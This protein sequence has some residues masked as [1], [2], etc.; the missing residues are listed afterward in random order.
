MN[1]AENIRAKLLE[2]LESGALPLKACGKAFLQVLRPVLDSRVVV[3]EKSGAG[4]RLVVHDSEAL[5]VFF[6][7][8]FHGGR[9]KKIEV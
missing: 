5:R 9:W 3:E 1:A 4:R 6:A 7:V 2:L 8:R